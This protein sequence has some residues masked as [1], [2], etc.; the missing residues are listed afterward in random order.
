MLVKFRFNLYG[1]LVDH[2]RPLYYFVQRSDSFTEF[3][4]PVMPE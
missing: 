3:V 2:G 1:T 4:M